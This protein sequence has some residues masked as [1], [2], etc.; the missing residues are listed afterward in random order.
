[1]TSKKK[2]SPATRRAR[3]KKKAA[4][5]EKSPQQRAREAIL[6]S[7]GETVED[8]AATFEDDDLEVSLPAVTPSEQRDEPEVPLNPID[9]SEADLA[10][11]FTRVPG[12]EAPPVELGGTEMEL[13]VVT[14]YDRTRI[15][16]DTLK[17]LQSTTHGVFP[18]DQQEL[19]SWTQLFIYKPLKKDRHRLRSVI[20]ANKRGISPDTVAAIEQAQNG[21]VIAVD[22]V[23]LDA[24]T[25][26]VF[27]LPSLKKVRH[28]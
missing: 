12:E 22:P 6:A 8:R 13:V 25:P 28:R 21:A 3:S 27:H 5:M 18:V 19:D 17:A 11:T 7:R 24:F 9:L 23:E 16:P 20:L 10:D 26:M 1:M 15:Q 2:G 4:K 14:L